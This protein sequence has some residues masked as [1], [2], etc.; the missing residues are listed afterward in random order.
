VSDG[1]RAWASE[2]ELSHPARVIAYPAHA[3]QT[4]RAARV[5]CVAQTSKR[6]NLPIIIQGI[7]EI[8]A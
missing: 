1:L 2:D 4:V 6:T 3:R 8:C 7:I 5:F